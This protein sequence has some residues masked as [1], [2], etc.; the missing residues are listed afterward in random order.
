M[1]K[2]YKILS[3]HILTECHFQDANMIKQT[4][5]VKTRYKLLDH[6]INTHKLSQFI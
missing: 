5:S 2:Y 6:Y 1:I 3:H 4:Q